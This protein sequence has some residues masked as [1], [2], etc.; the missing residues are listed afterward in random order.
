[1]RQSCHQQCYTS[2]FSDKVLERCDKAYHLI[3]RGINLI[4][5]DKQPRIDLDKLIEQITH[6]HTPVRLD[7]L[8]GLP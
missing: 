8:A 5:R 7:R 6:L 3:K 4:H 1:M 2:T